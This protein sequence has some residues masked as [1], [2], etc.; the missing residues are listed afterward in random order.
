MQHLDVV[1]DVLDWTRSRHNSLN[2]DTDLVLID[3][4]E[5]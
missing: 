2:V 4:E 1:D 5:M 3:E